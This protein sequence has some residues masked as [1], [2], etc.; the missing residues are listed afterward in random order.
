ML[1]AEIQLTDETINGMIRS[2]MKEMYTASQDTDDT[3]DGEKDRAALR[4]VYE[5]VTPSS[6]WEDWA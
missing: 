3:E 6:E 2:E 4:R 1:Y 5:F